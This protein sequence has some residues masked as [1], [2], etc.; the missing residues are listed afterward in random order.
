[1]LRKL[2]RF[3]NIGCFITFIVEAALLIGLSAAT[4]EYVEA[5]TVEMLNRALVIL[6]TAAFTLGIMAVFT[7]LQF[8]LSKEEFV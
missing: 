3:A 1:M 2:R 8:M 7:A 6:V 4:K 5:R